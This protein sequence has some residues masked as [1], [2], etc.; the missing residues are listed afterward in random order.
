MRDSNFILAKELLQKE[1]EIERLKGLLAS[2]EHDLGHASNGI[3]RLGMRE[4]RLLQELELLKKENALLEKKN[5]D[6]RKEF[7]ASM[8]NRHTEAYLMLE[9]DH[10]RDDVVR[11][12]KMLKTTKEVRLGS[13]STKTLQ[14]MLMQVGLSTTSKVWGSSV[15]SIWHLTKSIKTSPS[16]R[17]RSSLSMRR[18]SGCLKQHISL[19]TSSASNMKAK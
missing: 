16:V 14:T 7:Q 1:A 8:E 15:D 6:L 9:N 12:I 18:S 17:I 19:H 3:D 4:D 5:Q 11:L 2:R 10:L 13:R